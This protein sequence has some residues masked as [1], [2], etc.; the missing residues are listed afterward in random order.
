MSYY[1]LRIGLLNNPVSY[2]NPDW[3]PAVQTWSVDLDC[4][5]WKKPAD[6]QRFKG[7]LAEPF[8]LALDGDPE[9]GREVVEGRERCDEIRIRK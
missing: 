9:L 6:R 5:P 1:P 3:L 8:L 7:S 2:L 4:F